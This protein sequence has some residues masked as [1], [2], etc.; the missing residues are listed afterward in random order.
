[1][2]RATEQLS[3]CTTASEAV[4]QGPHAATTQAHS[5][6]AHAPQQEKP[7]QWKSCITPQTNRISS[8]L[9]RVNPSAQQWRPSEAKNT[10]KQDAPE[11]LFHAG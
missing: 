7:P 1:M 9:Q 11:N 4:L 8:S 2:R 10:D 6:R 3:L 5:S